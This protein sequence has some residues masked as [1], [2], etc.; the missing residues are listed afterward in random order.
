MNLGKSI[1]CLQEDRSMPCTKLAELLDVAPQQLSRWRR[2]EDLKVSVALKV[3]A[4]FGLTL[5]ELLK[6]GIE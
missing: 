6:H 3:A 1:R 4:V 2:S 5:D